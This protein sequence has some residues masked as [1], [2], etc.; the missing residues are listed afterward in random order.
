[1]CIFVLTLHVMSC[2]CDV[3]YETVHGSVCYYV[4]IK[5]FVCLCCVVD[6]PAL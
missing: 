3:G 5:W 1:M 2:L 6:V 4:C